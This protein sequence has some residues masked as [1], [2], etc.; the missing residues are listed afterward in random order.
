MGQSAGV[1]EDVGQPQDLVVHTEGVL[2]VALAEGE[3]TDQGLTAGQVAVGLQPHAALGLPA[4]FLHALLDLLKQLGVALLQEVVQNRLAGHEL[5]VGILLHQLQDSG[6]GAGHLLAG[7]G[8]GPPP[9]HVDVGMA[10]AGG[11]DVIIAAHLLIQLHAQVVDG[12]LDGGLEGG[13]VGDPQVQQVD[14]LIEDG[15]HIQT[16]LV[17]GIHTAEGPQGDLQVV[18]Q[19]VHILVQLI[20]LGQEVELPVQGAGVGLDVDGQLGAGHGLVEQLHLTV[21]DVGAL[22]DLTVDEDQE[23][24]VLAVVPLLQ[25]R[26]DLEPDG[27][28]VHVLGD[29]DGLAEPVVSAHDA[30]EI[31]GLALELTLEDVGTGIGGV[32]AHGL[33]IED[34]PGLRGGVSFLGPEELALLEAP[35]GQTGGIAETEHLQLIADDLKS[36]IDKVHYFTSQIGAG[37]ITSEGWP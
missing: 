21:V 28:A 10:D 26:V 9:G 20:E 11:D 23:L 19:L 5:V 31:G 18:V 24:G 35:L 14:G 34:L 29:C 33:G 4:A 15:L 27:L 22:A 17:V 30:L 8:D 37:S 6:E 16:D 7:L 25:T 36:L 32:P 1:A 2:E 3:L 12:L 13:A